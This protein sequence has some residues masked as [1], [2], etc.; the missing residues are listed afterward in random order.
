MRRLAIG[1][2]AA[3]VFAVLTLHVLRTDVNPLARGVSRYAVGEY[4]YVVNVAFLLLAA[5]LVAT[6]IGFRDGPQAGRAGVWLL[7][8]GA[9]GMVAVAIFP[10]RA[11]DSAAMANLPHQVG[12]MVFFVASAAGAVL[13]S[14]ATTRDT[15][16]AWA[17]AAAVT[18]YFLS[19]GVPALRLAAVRGLL[20]RV[21]F[22]AI[23]I[24][25]IRANVALDA[26]AQRR[27]S[28]SSTP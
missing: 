19:I 15:V 3:F 26:R 5:A 12:G 13:L 18:V 1:M 23:V 22:A 6:G 21:C 11:A 4:G 17:T 16:P 10:A 7:W 24:W 28:A 2:A 27:Q 14:R 20:Q 25:V 9:A 8:L